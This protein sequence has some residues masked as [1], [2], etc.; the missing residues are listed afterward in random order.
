MRTELFS[1]FGHLGCKVCAK[2]C[3]ATVYGT[4][5]ALNLKG[6]IKSPLFDLRLRMWHEIRDTNFLGCREASRQASVF[7]KV[8]LPSLIKS[9]GAV[10]ASWEMKSVF[11]CW[12]HKQHLLRC[13]FN[14]VGVVFPTVPESKQII[15]FL[16]V[17][18]FAAPQ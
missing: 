10:F 1:M 9:E 14:S 3:H 12:K 18:V 15:G 6:L 7:A 13:N 11:P 2:L 16:V 8:F 17:K 5:K 4:H